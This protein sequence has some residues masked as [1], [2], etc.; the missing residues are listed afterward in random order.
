MRRF[1]LA[2]VLCLSP[3]AYAEAPTSQPAVPAYVTTELN[4]LRKQV[5]ELKEQ[6][7]KLTRENADLKAGRPVASKPGEKPK[8]KMYDAM[9]VFTENEQGTVLNE[10]S[11]RPESPDAAYAALE[12]E[13][14]VDAVIGILGGWQRDKEVDGDRIIQWEYTHNVSTRTIVEVTFRENKA[15]S[16]ERRRG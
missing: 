13:M 2:A 1:I 11:M 5:M 14:P 15:I 6:V 16:F 12:K 7:A 8:V 4:A 3:V 10:S 9:K